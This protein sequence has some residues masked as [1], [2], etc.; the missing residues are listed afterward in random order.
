MAPLSR[1]YDLADLADLGALKHLVLG[2]T[3]LVFAALIDIYLAST[4]FFYGA[5]PLAGALSFFVFGAATGVPIQL[6]LARTRLA[7]TLERAAGGDPTETAYDRWAAAKTGALG[8]ASTVTWLYALAQADP[9]VVLPLASMAPV[10][11]FLVDSAQGKILLKQA[12]LPLILV[13]AGFWIVRSPGVIAAASLTM[14]VVLALIL[15]NVASAGSELFERKGAAGS[16]SGFTAFRF[17]WLA[18]AGIPVALVAAYATGRGEA[19]QTLIGNAWPVALPLHTVTMALTFFGGIDRISAKKDLP[20]SVCS[21]AYATP[22]VLAPLVAAFANQMLAGLFPTVVAS[23]GMFLGAALVVGGSGWLAR[24][25]CL[26]TNPN[27]RGDT[28]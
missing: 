2:P 16:L 8:A 25:Q 27:L 4:V 3:A 21:A 11:L 15:R 22:Q 23:P 10:L 13:L 19:C 9:T 20:L 14:P 12:I 6:A 24:L 1:S 17:C 5:D 18:I 7:R 26:P 28:E